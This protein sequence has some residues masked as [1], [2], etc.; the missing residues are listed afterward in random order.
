MPS[1]LTAAGE[2]NR[3]AK[4]RLIVSGNVG[5]GTT[6]PTGTLGIIGT[7]VNGI[8]L[9]RYGS[10]FGTGI[11]YKTGYG[12]MGAPTAAGAGAF[13]GTT[14]YMGYDGVSAFQTTAKI[15]SQAEQAVTPTDSRGGLIF[16]TT[17]PGATSK[18]EKVRIDSSGNVGI[19]TTAPQNK[20]DVNGAASIG[21]NLAAPSNGLIVSGQTGIGTTAPNAAALLDVYSTSQGFLPPRMTNAQEIAIGT[22]ANSGGLLAYNTTLNELDVYDSATQQWEAVGANAADAAGSTGQVQFNNGGDLGASANFFWDNT[23]NRLGIGTSTMA[24]AF[25]VNGNESIGYVD[26]AAPTNGLLVKGNV[27]IGTTSPGSSLQVNGGAAIGY[28]TS[29]AAPSNGLIV[30]GNL[31]DT[32]LVLNA[33]GH[34]VLTASGEGI[35]SLLNNAGTDFNR[36]DFGGTTSAFPGLH[37]LNTSTGTQN[38]LQ[39][40]GADGSANTN[41]LVTGSVGIGTTAPNAAALLDVY[42]TSK[43]LL[44]PRMTNAQE[45]AIGTNANSGGLLV[46]NTTLNELDVYDSATGQWEAVGANAA[47]AAGSTGQVQFNS[48]G[49]LAASANFFWNNA[50]N[51]LGI[52]TSAPDY[53]LVLYGANSATNATTFA[54]QTPVLKIKNSDPTVGNYE[55]IIFVNSGDYATSAIAGINQ[56]SNAGDMAFITHVGGGRNEVMRITSGGS[57]GIGTATPASTLGVYNGGLAVG[58][59]AATA[60]VGIGSAVFSGY[61]GIGTTSPIATLDVNGYAHL[62][63]NAS[64]PIACDAAHDGSLALAST[65]RPC[66]CVGTA[67]IDVVY[68]TACSW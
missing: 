42:S 49:D 28:S 37:S 48:G 52:G 33:S 51:Y 27:G 60:N 34:A 50:S 10:V 61:V 15:Y 14:E 5:I 30:A 23:N 24:S 3:R 64:Q 29:T 53:T 62:A 57:V 25:E 22:N 17:S 32:N 38:A 11:R 26:T 35:L 31:V 59:Y 6:A 9:T 12:T 16:A 36:I 19:G 63:K 66:E 43:G 20:L 55:G 39:V 67:W 18:S 4:Q 45:I 47:D 7:G 21:Y 41:L 46:Y 40:I 44:P 2:H 58:T 8:D 68:G 54:A 56:A 13:T 1:A 65:R